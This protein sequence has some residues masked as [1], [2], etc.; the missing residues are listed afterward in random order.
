MRDENIV[1]PELTAARKGLADAHNKLR[2]D[3]TSGKNQELVKQASDRVTALVEELQQIKSAKIQAEIESSEQYSARIAEILLDKINQF[4]VKQIIGQKGYMV[5]INDEYHARDLTQIDREIF[6]FQNKTEQN[7]FHSL[8]EKEN[9]NY[10][11]YTFTFGYCPETTF[12]LAQGV[13]DNWLKAQEY[14]GIVKTYK[15]PQGIDLLM[16]SLSA[17]DIE[18]RDHLE[19]CIVR[20]YRHPGDYKIPNLLMFGQGGVGKNELNTHILSKI[21]KKSCAVTNFKTLTE[22][23]AM[24]LGKVCVLVDETI[25]SKSD[26]DRF[27]SI[28]G[29]KDFLMKKLYSDVVS[30]PNIMWLHVSGQGAG[31]PLSISNDSTTRRISAIHYTKDLFYWMAKRK[32]Q[33]YD[34]K[35]EAEYKAAWDRLVQE[36]FTDGN[37]SIWL[38]YLLAKIKED[39]PV[40]A[41]HGEAFDRMVEAHKSPLDQLIETV[42]LADYDH[43]PLAFMMDDLYIVYKEIGKQ[44]YNN[45]GVL[46]RNKFIAGLT[47]QVARGLV[48]GWRY[49][50]RQSWQLNAQEGQGKMLVNNSVNG[51]VV[52]SYNENVYLNKDDAGRVLGL[53]NWLDERQE[54]PT[55]TVLKGLMK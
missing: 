31:G 10:L 13:S 29:N 17:G 12:N 46:G 5:K 2:R 33:I 35:D 45:R 43:K 26:Y 28:A 44:H 55:V 8:L 21:F 11:D 40:A 30:V 49:G 34:K 48:V 25:D 32:N 52:R 51:R 22:N 37:L 39:R 27:K 38:G 54:K 18:I 1:R 16:E 4:D 20:K 47:D 9:R 14:T 24:L 7:I 23:P 50:E 6:R 15:C 41:Y 19:E 3:E 36:D 53:H 42:L